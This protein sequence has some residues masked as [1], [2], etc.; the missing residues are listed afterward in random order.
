VNKEKMHSRIIF[1]VCSIA[2]LLLMV[3]SS[4]II[5]DDQYSPRARKISS[6][7]WLSAHHFQPLGKR[8]RFVF[9]EAPNAHHYDPT[10][11]DL[12]NNDDAQDDSNLDK[13][14]WRL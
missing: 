6:G 7:A 13:R 9:R 3:S 1:V 11:D 2:V 5:T 14:N 4:A 12:F 8:G 10:N